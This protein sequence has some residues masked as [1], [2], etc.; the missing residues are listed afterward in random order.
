MDTPVGSERESYDDRVIAAQARAEFQR[1]VFATRNARIASADGTATALAATAAAIAA[2]A[3]GALANADAAWPWMVGVA[4]SAVLA[5]G[6]AI[7]SRLEIP[8]RT[9]TL[10][11]LL[12]VSGK[13]VADVHSAEDHTAQEMHDRIFETWRAMTHSAQGRESVK[14]VLAW[15]VL[16]PIAVEV[17]VFGLG[18]HS[19]PETSRGAVS[20]H[21]GPPSWADS[22][23]H[24]MPCVH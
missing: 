24:E 18:L 6:V 8:F 19:A 15:C 16:V 13:A 12:D 21:G 1:E 5:V 3:I 10:K 23:C 20:R 2:F 7:W 9:G 14:R 22:Y 11:P 17:L 4:V